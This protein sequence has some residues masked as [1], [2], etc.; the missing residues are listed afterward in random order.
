[1]TTQELAGITHELRFWQG[2]V[3]TDRFLKG[4]VA[5]CVTPELNHQVYDF[6]HGVLTQSHDRQGVKI[7]DVGSGVVSILNGL[8][9]KANLTAVDPLG[10]L[11]EFVFDYAKHKINPPLPIPAEEL[12]DGMFSYQFD[13]VHISNALDHCQDPAAAYMALHS[14]VKKDGFLIIQGFENEANYEQWQGF[15]QWNI[16]LNEGSRS[17]HITGKADKQ[18]TF[19]NPHHCFK[20]TFENNKSW[21]VWIVKK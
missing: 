15:H 3:K 17:L 7:L 14:L 5:D 8:V 4:W 13:I 16:E 9:P 1:M 12:K 19:V 2:F 11:Y 10:G 20:F 18:A 6:I 21:F